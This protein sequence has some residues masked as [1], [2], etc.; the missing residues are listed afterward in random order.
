M[1]FITVRDF[2]TSPAKIWKELPVEQEMIITNNGKPIALMTP[3]SDSDLEETLASVRK[4]KAESALITLQLDSF[5]NGL[6]E[7]S[8]D[9]INNEIS[10]YRESKN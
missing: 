4:A 6:S 8:M 7:M 1:K 5:R 10:E 9:D 3:I 2:R